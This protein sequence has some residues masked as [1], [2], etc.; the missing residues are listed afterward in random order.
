VADRV[1]PLTMEEE[2]KM[3]GCIGLDF[4]VEAIQALF[5]TLDAARARIAQVE[6]E[7]DGFRNGQAQVQALFDGLWKSNGALIKERGALRAEVEA[8]REWHDLN[9]CHE[10]TIMHSLVALR[11]LKTARRLRAQNEGGE[12]G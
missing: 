9:E 2:R 1:E 12:R 4:P 8:W 11:I 3:R 5:A 7:R 6:A 10:G